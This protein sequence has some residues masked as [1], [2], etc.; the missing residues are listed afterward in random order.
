MVLRKLLV[1]D[2]IMITACVKKK[3]LLG[4]IFEQK[5][6]F[7]L[8]IQTQ[9]GETICFLEKLLVSIFKFCAWV[10]FYFLRDADWPTNN[11]L[12]IYCYF[13]VIRLVSFDYTVVN[14]A[15]TDV[16]W[17]VFNTVKSAKK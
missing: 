11:F 8:N 5:N 4:V 14:G 2:I 16:L 1:N 6:N 7:F 15:G 9:F 17:R 10:T 13:P 12:G 3:S